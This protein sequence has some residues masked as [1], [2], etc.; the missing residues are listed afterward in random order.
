MYS[1]SLLCLVLFSFLLMGRGIKDI[2]GMMLLIFFSYLQSYIIMSSMATSDLVC[3]CVFVSMCH[4]YLT[5]PQNSQS[6]SGKVRM[7]PRDPRRILHNNI[8]QKSESSVSDQFKVTGAFPSI[9]LV[10]KDNILAREQGKHA[11]MSSHSQSIPLPDIA[12]QFT[13]KLRNIADILSNSQ[14]TNMPVTVPP[15]IVQPIPPSKTERLAIDSN[16]QQSGTGLA[17]EEASTTSRLPNPWG[18]VEH[19][20][21]GYDD[22]QKAA[23]QK[24]RARRIEE[25]NKMFAARKLCLVLDLDHTL[26]N[27]AKV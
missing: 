7:K 12:P 17:H 24:E 15:N 22:Q 11:M 25:Q 4:D 2:I 18:D 27:S 8:V 23:I 20:F 6:E 26:L 16:D 9:A 1:I 3:P 5:Y 21:E 13:K 10:G 19:L 14:A